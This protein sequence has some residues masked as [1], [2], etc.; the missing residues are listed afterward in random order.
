[1]LRR[2]PSAARGVLWPTCALARSQDLGQFLRGFV[3]SANLRNI[4]CPFC[5]G[6]TDSLRK[7]PQNF[8]NNCAEQGQNPG[9]Q[10]CLTGPEDEAALR[11]VHAAVER[12]LELPRCHAS[13]VRRWPLAPP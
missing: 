10:N 13:A 11:A 7:S 3:V 9:S 2:S 1:M 4:C 8:H 5:R 6:E 12:Q